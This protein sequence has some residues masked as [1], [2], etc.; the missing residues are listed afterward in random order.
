MKPSPK[1]AVLALI[2]AL[3]AAALILSP[4]TAQRRRTPARS[5]G[6]AAPASTPALP[7]KS[8][9]PERRS[10]AL[11]EEDERTFDGLLA[12][13]SYAVYG[14]VR[15]IGQLIRSADL[16]ELLQPLRL[17]AGSDL[18]PEITALI[19]FVSANADSLSNVNVSFTLMP[20]KPGLPE[21]L[22]GVKFSSIE[23]AN[24]FEPKIR[25]LLSS[26]TANQ[27]RPQGTPAAK[28]AVQKTSKG[29]TVSQRF[30][31]KRVGNLLLMSDKPFMLKNLRAEKNQTFAQD[32]R[33]QQARARLSS[34]QLFVFLNV[35][36]M[37]Q[38]S[39]VLREQHE[40]KIRVAQTESTVEAQKAELKNS[41]GQSA[42]VSGGEVTR[43]A[44][45][46]SVQTVDADPA[47]LPPPDERAPVHGDPNQLQTE[48]PPGNEGSD[49]VSYTHLT[50][51]TT[52]Y[53]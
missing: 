13:D 46:A 53:V 41:E 8:A 38:N 51:P 49:P 20:A 40:E 30:A 21:N 39:K 27:A 3:I 34:E 18:P 10:S 44:P 17:L 28:R 23:T 45:T 14:E 52:P 31:I 6:V 2:P 29:E 48:A 11:G 33:F 16:N 12:S 19:G 24:S 37:E 36:L 47:L 32:V 50:L 15:M 1:R 4:A 43:V 26:L 22:V 42:R 35:G 25:Q 5:R 7:V 9:A